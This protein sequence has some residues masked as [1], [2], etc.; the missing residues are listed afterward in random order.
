MRCD[1]TIVVINLQRRID[2][3]IEAGNELSRI[4]WHAKYFS[5]IEAE[6]EAG[7]PSIG[8]RGCFLSHLAVLRNAK[9]AGV[10]RLVILEDDVNFV[11]DFPNRWQS[12]VATLE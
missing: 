4:G 3:R 11:R 7:F 5:A 8:A 10:R 12:A 9:E 2:R 1:P 6:S